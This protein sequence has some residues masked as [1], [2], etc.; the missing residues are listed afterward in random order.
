LRVETLIGRRIQRAARKRALDRGEA[1]PI[2]KPFSKQLTPEFEEAVLEFLTRPGAQ[3]TRLP[4]VSPETARLIEGA[5]ARADDD[6]LDQLGKV[7]LRQL[8]HRV[9]GEPPLANLRKT[10]LVGAIR[11]AKAGKV[12]AE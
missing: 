1:D 11:A 9:V 5:R 2:L 6:G 3:V 4:T 7:E 12:A 10:A 8:H